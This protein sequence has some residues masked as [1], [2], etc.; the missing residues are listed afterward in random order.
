MEAGAISFLYKDADEDDL[1][2]AIRLA[3]KAV[4]LLAPEAM[5]ALVRETVPKTNA[6]SVEALT[7]RER[8]ILT[9]VS[10]GMTNPQIA[11]KLVISPSTVH[12]HIHNTLAK[13]Q[14]ETRAEAVA[15]AIRND[16]IQN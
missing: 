16:L 7:N 2:S 11:E 14:A 9:L 8:E 3:M 1:L 5:Q 4:R 10:Q 6:P 15:I 12:F 13:L